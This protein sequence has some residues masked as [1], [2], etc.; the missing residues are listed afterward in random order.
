MSLLVSRL[1]LASLAPSPLTLFDPCVKAVLG[2]AHPAACCCP[3]DVYAHCKPFVARIESSLQGVEAKVHYALGRPVLSYTGLC[4]TPWCHRL[5][6]SVC[7]LEWLSPAPI[8]SLCRISC[9][10]VP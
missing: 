1:A 5:G 6:G 3:V 2:M 7:R 4:R 8:S 9:W 10:V